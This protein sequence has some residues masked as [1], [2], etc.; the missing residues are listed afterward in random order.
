MTDNDRF[1]VAF[2]HRK[3]R[4]RAHFS[5]E[6]IFQ[7][8]RRALGERIDARVVTSPYL[9]N[10]LVRRVANTVHAGF[11]QADVNHITGDTNYL[12]MGL[13]SRR[14]VLTIHDCSYLDRT[15]G[16]RRALLK[17]F[18]VTWPV[19]CSRIITTVSGVSRNVILANTKC[20]PD[21]IKVIY[22]P[23]SELYQ[24]SE[25]RSFP[26]SPRVLQVGTAVNKNIERLA[27]ALA[28]IDC[29]LAI[30]G[31]LSES[32]RTALATHNIRYENLIELSQ[33]AIVEQYRLA[34]VIAFAS[35]VE[36]FGMPIVEANASGRPIVTSCVSS[37]PEIA[38][39]A[40]VLVDPWD[41]ASIRNGF[42]R[43]F[44][45]AELRRGLVERGV[46]NARRFRIEE[47]AEQYLAVYRTI[48]DE[49]L[50]KQGRM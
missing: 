47:I 21:K 12:A 27:A 9:S 42:M 17:T 19:R 24:F 15:S 45:D 43:V 32:Q 11:H 23:I 22:N 40:A 34:D 30:V 41:V 28:G 48:R 36:G 39:D 10:G 7:E 18:W 44:N 13:S 35:T 38:A 8:V 5:I 6:F 49:K 50:H 2:L 20:D 25:P 31:V 14:T 26:A 3:R 29:T 4:N 33:E 1:S 46:V 16:W 37:M